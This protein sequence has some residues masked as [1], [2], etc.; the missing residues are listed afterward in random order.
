MSKYLHLISLCLFFSA[1][2][3]RPP[4]EWL[5]NKVEEIE[6]LDPTKN[7]IGF[8]SGAYRFSGARA[9]AAY[10]PEDCTIYWPGAMRRKENLLSQYARPFSSSEDSADEGYNRL[11]VTFGKFVG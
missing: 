3:A 7:V 8:E 5:C 1:A 9:M 4:A 2:R 10:Y 6:A 11:K